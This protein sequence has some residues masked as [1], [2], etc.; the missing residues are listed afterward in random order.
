MQTLIYPRFPTWEELYA[1]YLASP[2]W[3][4]MRN[5]VLD[6]DG[7]LCQACLCREAS[8]VHH[9]SYTLYNRLG[10]SAAFELVAIC[11]ECHAKIHPHIAKAQAERIFAIES[12]TSPNHD[13]LRSKVHP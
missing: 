4:K 13:A 11:H 12:L 2:H 6:R 5:L 9:T 1:M 10:R 8:E 3:Y 7:H